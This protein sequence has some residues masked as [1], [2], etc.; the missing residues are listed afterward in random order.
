[1][2]SSYSRSCRQRHLNNKGELKKFDY[3]HFE[4]LRITF[5][6]ILFDNI[7]KF[8]KSY[9]KSS[10]EI[11]EMYLLLKDLKKTYTKGYYVYGVSLMSLTLLLKI[12]KLL[13]IILLD[14]LLILLFQKEESL[15][16]TLTLI[17]LLG[18]MTTMK[19]K[20]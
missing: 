14:M 8:Y 16:L 3:F 2:E 9:V 10:A 17:K 19:I 5:R 7:Y 20:R 13:L 1:M 6:N 12:L 18:S 4:Y 11:R 15:T